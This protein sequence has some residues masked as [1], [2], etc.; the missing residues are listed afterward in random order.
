MKRGRVASAALAF[1]LLALSLGAL[2]LACTPRAAASGHVAVLGRDRSPRLE[3]AFDG[4]PALL[5]VIRPTKLVRDPLYG[6]LIRR[7]SELA[8]ARVAVAEAVGRTAL[9]AIERTEEVTIGA[10]DADARDAVIALRGVPADIEASSVLD[11]TGKPLW[12]HRSDL[13]GGVEELAPAEAAANAALFVLPRRAWV[14]AVGGAVARARATYGAEVHRVGGPFGAVADAPLVVARLRGA[15]LRRAR[16]TLA[17]GPLAPL[18]RD[19]EW[20]S[21]DLEPG[22]EG[23]VGEVALRLEYGELA[24]AVGAE[25]C[26]TDVLAALTRKYETEA[27]WLHAVKVS[28][29]ERAIAV[30]GRIPRA[31]TDGLLHVDVDDLGK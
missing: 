3:D 6:P 18:V 11:P 12:T 25:V 19:L 13:P 9:T 24:F 27:P 14:I 28:R 26:V 22:P 7:V 4:E 20:V 31:W 5:V 23:E 15:A 21:V 30:K 8:S 2:N 1:L 17:D 29:A 10:Y 16:P